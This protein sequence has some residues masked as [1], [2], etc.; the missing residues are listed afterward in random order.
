MANNDYSV[1]EDQIGDAGS[2]KKSLGRIKHKEVLGEQTDLTQE[3]RES[4]SKF[5]ENASKDRQRREEEAQMKIGGGW[6][7]INKEEMGERSLFYPSHY[8]FYVRPATVQAIKNWTA[9]DETN[10]VDVN[11]VLNE[12]LKTSV[13][14]DDNGVSAGWGRINSWDRFWFI[15]KVREATFSKGESKVEFQDVCSECGEEITY[16]LT[17]DALLF[18]IPDED[19]IEKHWTGEHWEID[20]KEYNVDHAPIKLYT[21]TCQKDDAIIRWAQA[22]AQ[23]KKTIDE[24]FVKYLMWMM[25]KP[26]KDQLLD[27]QINKLYKEYKSWTPE[28]FNFMDDVVTNLSVN[29]SENLSTTCPSCD[30]RTVSTVQ[31]PNGIKQ[32]FTI[33][34]SAKKFGSR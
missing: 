13:K 16:T 9:V 23:T 5:K 22:T 29:P 6:I 25:N 18:D 8:Q 12:I 31:F 30:R 14:I 21:P 15:M 7:P 32:L 28:F 26:V 11:N 20:P 33:K 4:L 34:T 27:D 1:L 24:K 3:E 2:E 10:S 19:L 17:A